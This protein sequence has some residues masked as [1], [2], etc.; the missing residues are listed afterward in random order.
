MLME[1]RM[2]ITCNLHTLKH[3][4]LHTETWN[5]ETFSTFTT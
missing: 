5:M 1:Y 3:A 2:L 4:N